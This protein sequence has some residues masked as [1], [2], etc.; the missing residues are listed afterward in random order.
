VGQVHHR[1]GLSPEWYIGAYLKY[2]HLVSD[3]LSTAFGRDQEQFFQTSMSLTKIIH[4]D[5]GLT[6]DAYHRSAQE[7]LTEKAGELE[8]FNSQLRHLQAAKQFLTDLIVHDL[9]NPLTGISSLLQVLEERI[10]GQPDDVRDAVREGLS[11]CNNLSEM[12]HNVLGVSRGES[13]KLVANLE[14]VDLTYEVTGA[15]QTFRLPFSQEGRELRFEAP[16][17]LPLQTDRLLVRRIVQNLLRNALRHTPPGTRVAVR[18]ELLEGG[19]ARLSVSDNGSG[20]PPEVHGF[21]FDPYAGTRLR[22]AG[23]R[24]DTGLGL[25]FCRVAS[26][27]LGGIFS[28]KSDGK[29]G[30]TFNLDLPSGSPS[31]TS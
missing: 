26:E 25:V 8:A 9:Q 11:C 16:T 12:I 13:G 30:T 24:V 28:L 23:L 3:V 29:T 17:V 14:E 7:A 18:L 22:K 1:I 27:A 19:R 31:P 6:L 15:I 21:L 5:M 4:L 2:Q 10:E 20:I